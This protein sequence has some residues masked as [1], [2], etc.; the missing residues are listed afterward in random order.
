V[1]TRLG[2]LL[3]A[4]FLAAGALPALAQTRPLLTEPA[5]TAPAG[6]LVLETGFDVIADEPSYVSGALRTGW[7]GP[8][9]RF[10]YSPARNVELDLE[11]VA[12]VGEWGEEG[13]GG[14]QSSD[15]GDASFRAKWRIRDGG[16]RGATLGARFGVIY[17]ET[18][19][20]DKQFRP[21]GLGPNTIRTYV[22]ALY[23]QPLGGPRVHANAG[24]FVFD[25]VYRG[26]DQRDFFSYGLALEWPAA[27]SVTL[28][29]EVAGRYGDG[30]PGSDVTSE[31]RGG[32]R[33]GTG[34]LRWDA[35]V[36]RGLAG[37]D[38][39]WGVTAG[40]AWTILPR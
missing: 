2:A 4:A 38:G 3:G 30:Q 37:P 27:R 31:A 36:R 25:E 35:A 23:T 19:Y 14:A 16:T 5:V 11:W 29:A 22:E 28:L 21:L 15:F 20:E 24:L 13:R 32:V 33:L 40:L 18:S 6:T 39:T 9:L 10:V 34:G 7:A 17:P 26:H 12:R 1:K 8:L